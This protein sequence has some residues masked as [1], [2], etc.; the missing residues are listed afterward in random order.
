[1]RRWC[2]VLG[3]MAGFAALGQ[4]W[5]KETRVALVVGA[6]A[7]Q[8]APALPNPPNDARL[9]GPK[10]EQLGFQ[11]ETVLDPDYDQLKSA[12]RRF[13]QRLDGAQVALFY[14][15]GHGLQVAGHNYL[16]PTSAKLEHER[17]LTFEAFDVQ[18]VLDQ[19][20]APTRV[21]IVVLDACRDNPFTRSLAAHMGTR[22]AVV[23]QGLG[24]SLTA[25]SGTMIAYATDPDNVAE[26]GNGKDSPF[27]EAFARHLGEPGLELNQMLNRVKADVK[28]A[29]NGRQHPW[30]NGS[31]DA[32]F[33]FLPPDSAPTQP[34]PPAVLA[35]L[36]AGSASAETVFWQ[37]IATSTNKADYEAY[38]AQFP[39]GVFAGLARNRLAALS[40]PPQAAAEAD[41]TAWPAADRE[42]A[43][44]ALMTLGQLKSAGVGSIDAA[45]RAAILRW[46]AFAGQA[47]TGH[48]TM[49][50]RDALQA[51][52][53]AVQALL[54]VAPKSPRGT[55]ATGTTGAE[56]R[57]NLAIAFE[58]GD[59]RP[60]DPA[61]AVYWY[62][63][64]AADGWPA[65]YTNLGR[66]LARGVAGNKPDLAAAARMWRVAAALGDGT[67]MFDL[68]VMLE[69]GLG[70]P[71]DLA[72]A[73]RW[74]GRGA[75]AK[76]VAS[77]AALQ[78]LGG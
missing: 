38:L 3:V 41:D 59:E 66:L 32:D 68:G 63:L 12:I 35:N 78:R 74:Y 65:A 20:D 21:N 39:Q 27:S 1:M 13:G 33:F 15:A 34:H 47:D 55:A 56:D 62:T 6:G 26:D 10:L 29:T 24:R 61:E 16:V 57:F 51:E 52:A 7:Y 40:A 28:A 64:A 37:S 60:K 22:A 5:A 53:Q 44:A 50:Q 18:T 75:A 46:Q 31:L 9:I 17:D 54:K 14:Y 69:R 43:L 23:G 11:V 2:V 73:K 58:N 70:V 48:L 42:A 77:A 72:L 49:A 4:A 76:N 45:A 67:A 25:A 19:M 36:P 8:N 71:A 30:V